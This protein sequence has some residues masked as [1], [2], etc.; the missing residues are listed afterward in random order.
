MSGGVSKGT[1]ELFVGAVVCGSEEGRGRHLSKWK[2]GNGP[3]GVV[4]ISRRSTLEFYEMAGDRLS[5]VPSH[6]SPKVEKRN[7]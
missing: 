3:A 4:Y 5:C 1:I 7:A 2:V 6:K